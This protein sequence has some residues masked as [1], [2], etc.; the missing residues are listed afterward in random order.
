MNEISKS[1]LSKKEKKKKKTLLV[2]SIRGGLTAL[3]GFT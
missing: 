1:I 2:S 3:K